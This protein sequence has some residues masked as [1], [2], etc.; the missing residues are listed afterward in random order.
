[1]TRELSFS[2]CIDSPTIRYTHS[3]MHIH[4]YSRYLFEEIFYG[5]QYH[6]VPPIENDSYVIEKDLYKDPTVEINSKPHIFLSVVWVVFIGG[7]GSICV[8]SEIYKII[9]L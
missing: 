5:K 3:K 1:M 9:L 8:L 6:H 4:K 7:M 2:A